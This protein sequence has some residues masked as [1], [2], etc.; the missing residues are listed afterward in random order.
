MFVRVSRALKLM[1]EKAR[2]NNPHQTQIYFNFKLKINYS[3]SHIHFLEF[4][5]GYKAVG[6][7]VQIKL[8]HFF[9]Y[10]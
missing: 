4:S 1:V 6:S 2:S 7:L 10:A 5:R 8:L 3:T 9:E